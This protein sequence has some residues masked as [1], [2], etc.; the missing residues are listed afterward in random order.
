M[1]LYKR[2]PE[3]SVRLLRLL[4]HSDEHPGIKCQLFTCTLL[5][6]GNT[7]PYEALSYVWGH[8][9]N[10]QSIYID[11]YQLSVRANLHAAMLHLQDRFMERIIWIDAICIN[12]EDEDEKGQQVQSMAKIYAKA[13]RVIVWLG[14]AADDSGQVLQEVAAARQVLIMCH[15]TEIDGYVFFSGLNA[16]NLA[17]KDPETQNRIRS[18]AYLIKG[19]IF[20][21]KYATNPSDRFSLNIHPL[22]ELVDAYHNRQATD[23]RDKVYA[24]L[25][26]SSDYIPTNLLPN[27]SILWADLFHRLIK[28]L[29]GEEMVVKTWDEEEIEIIKSKGCVLG[30]VSSVPSDGAWDDRQN[31]DITSKNTFGYLDQK[32]EWIARWTLQAPAKSIQKGDVVCLLKGAL[33]PT[34][35]RLFEDY[36]AV[37]AIAVTPT[38]DKRTEKVGINWLDVLPSITTFPSDFLLIWDWEKSWER[39][40]DEDYKCFIESRLPKHA[41]TELESYNKGL[42]LWDIGR[43]LGY[44][45]SNDIFLTVRKQ[46]EDLSKQTKRIEMENKALKKEIEALEKE[47]EL[48]EEA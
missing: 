24:L 20:R 41:R 2:L 9:N 42:S 26:M 43:I 4:P 34:I 38:D 8:E 48:E 16:L 36:C 33:K 1:P 18:A 17:S 31:V 29:I 15:S 7:H 22:G 40:E 28:F 39:L 5:D 12:Q 11:N 25:R 47:L 19:A 21:S 46:M 35:V 30:E 23:R 44:L 27:Y 10:Q 37:I 13:N 32:R 45:E 3:G 14:E 6:S